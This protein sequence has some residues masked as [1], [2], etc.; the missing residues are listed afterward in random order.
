MLGGSFRLSSTLTHHIVI[1]NNFSHD[2]N[3]WGLHSTD[4]HTVLMQGN[5]F[6]NSR[7]EHGAYVSDGSD[8]YVI[9]QNVFMGN[10]CLRTAMQHG[11]GIFAA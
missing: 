7:E 5:L 1:L 4:T 8:N 2:H 9:R 3:K 11:F 6:A 10:A